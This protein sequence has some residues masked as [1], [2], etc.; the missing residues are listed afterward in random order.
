[1]QWLNKLKIAIIEK[2]TEEIESLLKETPQLESV[3]DMKEAQYLFKE[4]MTLFT[5]LKD[6]T[7]ASM[8]Q[9]QKNLSFLRSTQTKP[10]PSLDIKL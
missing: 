4:A 2:K 6:E 8:K 1:M 3:E 5:T 9:I 7:Q 10:I